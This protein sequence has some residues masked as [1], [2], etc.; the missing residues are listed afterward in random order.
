MRGGNFEKFSDI[1]VAYLMHWQ[2]SWGCK[3]A[4]KR[5]QSQRLKLNILNFCS[6]QGHF[7]SKIS[8]VHPFFFLSGCFTLANGDFPCLLQ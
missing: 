2:G 5:S 6:S 3:S 1:I 7:L 8:T 4:Q